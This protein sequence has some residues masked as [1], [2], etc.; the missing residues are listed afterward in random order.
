MMSRTPSRRQIPSA[1]NRTAQFHD[2]FGLYPN[3]KP[4]FSCGKTLRDA[5][6]EPSVYTWVAGGVIFLHARCAVKLGEQLV[7]SGARATAEED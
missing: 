5:A 4:C 2:H 7:A 6:D 3:G 1:D